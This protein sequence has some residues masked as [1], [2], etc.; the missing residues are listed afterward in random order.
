MFFICIWIWINIYT[1]GITLFSFLRDI[2]LQNLSDLDIKLSRSLKIKCD[3]VIGIPIY[4][5]LLIF[6]GSIWLNSHPLRNISLRNLTLMFNIWLNSA[7]V[8]DIRLRN[9]SDM[10]FD[11]SRSLKVKCYGV[12]GLPT[13]GILLM[14]NSNIWPNS[15][16][17]RNI[18]LR[19]M[20]DL[21][22]NISRSLSSNVIVSM[23]HHVCFLLRFNSKHMA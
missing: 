16:R 5:F 12:L 3:D 1:Y 7:P 17:L 2:T 6:N 13:Y 8:H 18:S 9:L 23:A 11:L 22:T 19:N 20:T 15:A 21:D 14:L 10:Y 4:C